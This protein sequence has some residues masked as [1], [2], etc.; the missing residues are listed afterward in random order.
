MDTC[1]KKINKTLIGLW[2]WK[3]LLIKNNCGWIVA[4]ALSLAPPSYWSAFRQIGVKT[5][6]LGFSCARCL[7]SFFCCADGLFQKPNYENCHRGTDCTRQLCCQRLPSTQ[8]DPLHNCT[9][10]KGRFT[11]WKC[12][13]LIFIYLCKTPAAAS[14]SH[15]CSCVFR[16]FYFAAYSKSKDLFN[17]LFVPNSGLV[18][19][20]SAGV[21]GEQFLAFLSSTR[22][23]VIFLPVCL[24]AYHTISC[25]TGQI[26]MKLS[27]SKS[28]TKWKHI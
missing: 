7:F 11:L 28:T 22:Y 1:G 25:T 5:S 20:S 23:T 24:C 12:T 8:T 2:D 17:G 13:L 10:I 21:A 6:S 4:T 14:S 19:M 16:A 26:V 15:K 18:H 9:A 27:E 3:R